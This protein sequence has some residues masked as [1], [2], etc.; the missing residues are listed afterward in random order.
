MEDELDAQPFYQILSAFCERPNLYI[1]GAGVSVPY[2]LTTAQLKSK[3]I[4]QWRKIGSYPVAEISRVETFDRVI[5]AIDKKSNDQ[6]DKFYWHLLRSNSNALDWLITMNLSIDTNMPLPMNYSLFLYFP[7]QSVIL[8]FNLDQYTN[9]LRPYHIV[10]EPHGQIPED[11]HNIFSEN[12]I[13]EFAAF[14]SPT[15]WSDATFL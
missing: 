11:L 7:P 3:I 2:N 6:M 15:P 12:E 8:N 5:G 1:F 4:P 14:D 13:F 10:L 9:K